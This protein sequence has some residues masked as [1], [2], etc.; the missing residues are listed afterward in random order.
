MSFFK[1]KVNVLVQSHREVGLNENEVYEYVATVEVPS[2]ILFGTQK[3]AV[4]RALNNNKENSS[5]K[6]YAMEIINGK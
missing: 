4:E 6:L 5:V 2:F 1:K 3:Q